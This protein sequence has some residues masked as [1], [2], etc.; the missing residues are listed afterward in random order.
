MKYSQD[1]VTK[2]RFRYVCWA[3][4]HHD[5]DEELWKSI[6]G[7]NHISSWSFTLHPDTY[8]VIPLPESIMKLEIF[9]GSLIK[10]NLNQT[11][12]NTLIL[13]ET[14]F[15]ISRYDRQDYPDIQTLE[16]RKMYLKSLIN[17]RPSFPNLENLTIESPD[18]DLTERLIFSDLDERNFLGRFRL[19][20]K[21]LTLVS[22]DNIDYTK[23]GL[24]LSKF[25]LLTNLCF[26]NVSGIPSEFLI[27]I[28]RWAYKF[29]VVKF[30]VAG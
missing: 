6:R 21:C 23:L 11:R 9:R 5:W 8:K 27:V 25:L 29:L 24:I 30:Y 17:R 26:V 18:S 1:V 16:L 3:S 4:E 12:V 15:D 20:L 28:R 13:N 10:V 7:A 22:V 19:T 2:I 14:N